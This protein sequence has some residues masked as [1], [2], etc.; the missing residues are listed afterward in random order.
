MFVTLYETGEVHFCLFGT[1]GI[2]VKAENENFI[3]TGLPCRQNL[4]YE[5]F[6]SSFGRLRQNVQQKACRTIIFP[7]STNQIIDLWRCR[8]RCRRHFLNSL[9]CSWRRKF[10][11]RLSHHTPQKDEKSREV[12]SRW[13]LKIGI[14]VT[15]LAK[16]YETE[17]SVLW[18]WFPSV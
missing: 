5:N 1:N 10:V 9:V 15:V 18:Q 16:C 8:G 2:Y 17:K 13:T 3:A 11:S 4:K 14:L 7:R 12:I 6:T